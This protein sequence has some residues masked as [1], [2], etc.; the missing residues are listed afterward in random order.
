MNQH[1]QLIVLLEAFKRKPID[2]QYKLAWGM[3]Y[4]LFKIFPLDTAQSMIND[5]CAVSQ[6]NV[7]FCFP[8]SK[9]HEILI[10]CG[11]L[12]KTLELLNHEVKNRGKDKNLPSFDDMEQ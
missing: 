5:L 11:Y 7:I 8:E 4:S 6:G 2:E 1:E 9:R 3:F 10:F 12:K